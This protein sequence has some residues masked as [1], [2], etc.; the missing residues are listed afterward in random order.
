MTVLNLF[1]TQTKFWPFAAHCVQDKQNIE[2]RSAYDSTFYLGKYHIK[3][4]NERDYITSGVDYLIVH[5][6]WDAFD[7]RY[8]GDICIAVLSKSIRFTNSIIPLCIWPQS[9]NHEDLVDKAGL[10]A[11]TFYCCNFLFIVVI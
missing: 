6:D 11:G 4:L 9:D 8:K 2:K 5:P 3:D 1:V 7:E 10:V